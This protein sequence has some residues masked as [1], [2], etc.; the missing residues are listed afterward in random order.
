MVLLQQARL[1]LH[2]CWQSNLKNS[3]CHVLQAPG[4]QR[5]R[6]TAQLNS[7]SS[8]NTTYAA[9]AKQFFAVAAAAT[10]NGES[11]GTCSSPSLGQQEPPQQLWRSVQPASFVSP[12]SSSDSQDSQPSGSGLQAVGVSSSP[13]SQSSSKPQQRTPAVGGNGKSSSQHNRSSCVAPQQP[14]PNQ[15]LTG[16][17]IMRQ[18]KAAGSWQELQQL[19]LQHGSELNWRHS[20]ALLAH[21][22]QLSTHHQQEEPHEQQQQ[23]SVMPSQ[24]QTFGEAGPSLQQQAQHDLQGFVQLSLLPLLDSHLQSYDARGLANCLW[25]IAKLRAVAQPSSSWLQQFCSTSEPLLQQFDAQQLS[26]TLWGLVQLQHVPP[27]AWLQSWYAAMLQACSPE[28]PAWQPQSVSSALW[29]VAQLLVSTEGSSSG[30]SRGSSRSGRGSSGSRMGP[31]SDWVDQLLTAALQRVAAA[32]GSRGGQLCSLAGDGQVVSNALWACVQLQQQPRLPALLSLQSWLQRAAAAETSSGGANWRQQQLSDQSLA[33]CMWALGKLQQQHQ[34]QQHSQKVLAPHPQEQPGSNSDSRSQSKVWGV[35]H[36]CGRLLLK[37]STPRLQHTSSQHMS[38]LVWGAG[39]LSLR[40]QEPVMA[41]VLQQLAVRAD[42]LTDQQVSNLLWGLSHIK[43][44][45]Q[46]AQVSQQQQLQHPQHTHQQQASQE[47]QQQYQHQHRQQQAGCINQVLQ[48]QVGRLQG[49]SSQA[50][51][52]TLLSLARIQ[53][54]PQDDTLHAWLHALSSRPLASSSDAVATVDACCALALLRQQQ[55]QQAGAASSSTGWGWSRSSY[56]SS[57]DGQWLQGLCADTGNRLGVFTA[58]QLCALGWA[59]TLLRFRAPVP[60]LMAWQLAVVDKADSMS[61]VTAARALRVL[62]DLPGVAALGAA[63]L[64]AARTRLAAA[65]ARAAATAAAAGRPT[66]SEVAAAA[67]AVAAT[68]SRDGAQRVEQLLQAVPAVLSSCSTR[69]LAQLLCAAAAVQVPL[70]HGLLPAVLQHAQ[71]QHRQQQLGS[72]MM[73]L[74]VGVAKVQR[75]QQLLMFQQHPPQQQQ[76]QYGFPPSQSDH[77]QQ[78]QQELQEPSIASL[79]Q[80]QEQDRQQLLQWLQQ[81]VPQLPLS[82]ASPAYLSAVLWALAVLGYHPGS[83]WLE[84]WAQHSEPVLQ[85]MAPQQLASCGWALTVLRQ[86]PSAQ[87][88]AAWSRAVAQQLA[89]AMISPRSLALLLYSSA[90]LSCPVNTPWLRA[91]GAAAVRQVESWT[92]ADVADGLWGL[93]QLGLRAVADDEVLEGLVIGLVDATAAQ[94]QLQQLNPHRQLQVLQAAVL[95]GPGTDSMQHLQQQQVQGRRQPRQQQPELEQLLRNKR[96]RKLRWLNFRSYT[97]AAVAR[98]LA[99]AAAQQQQGSSAISSSGVP[100]RRAVSGAVGKAAVVAAKYVRVRT[101]RDPAAA[102]AVG[103]IKPGWYGYWC[104]CSLQQLPQWRPQQIAAALAA[105]AVLGYQPPEEWQQ[106]MLAHAVQQQQRLSIQTATAIQDALVALQSPLVKTWRQPLMVQYV[107]GRHNS[108]SAGTVSTQEL[109]VPAAAAPLHQQQQQ[110]RVGARRELSYPHHLRGNSMRRLQRRQHYMRLLGWWRQQQVI[111]QQY[112]QQR[113]Q[114]EEDQWRAAAAAAGVGSYASSSY[115][116]VGSYS[117]VSSIS[118]SPVSSVSD[119]ASPRSSIDG[120]AAAATMGAVA[121][122]SSS[123]TAGIVAP[124]RKLDS[125]QLLRPTARPA[126]VVPSA[127]SSDSGSSGSSSSSS[128]D[129]SSSGAASDSSSLQPGAAG[130][131]SVAGAMAAASGG[132]RAAA[133]DVSPPAAT[134]ASNGRNVSSSS[135]STDTSP[136]ASQASAVIGAAAVVVQPDTP[137]LTAAAWGH[138]WAAVAPAAVTEGGRFVQAGWGTSWQP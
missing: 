4:T 85:Q 36:H 14:G 138:S 16:A 82:I 46:H 102:A 44:Q 60:W 10:G 132:Q 99:A 23:H 58:E 27:R 31:S 62:Q 78:Q 25:A 126:P 6:P 32:A 24:Q 127:S 7:H 26:S 68:G 104:R 93:G 112:A 116:S 70:P 108:H 94:G 8:S 61:G 48:A 79:Q 75:Q 2:T 52:S 109:Q 22:A 72:G 42:S 1:F 119:P 56:T 19:V 66:A 67:A 81:V 84:V 57:A 38:L 80:G 20:S 71:H 123:T 53:H 9:G 129:D 83:S 107:P 65:A 18:L 121:S 34:E 54:I 29:A 125:R 15:Q 131:P 115:S 59:M 96:R 114:Q 55:Q 30:G 135:S 97:A 91:A 39:A 73:S 117:S 105:F 130:D 64:H 21:L 118:T 13:G 103:V 63:A 128:S 134:P 3:V 12:N 11:C 95:L 40:M 120:A 89:G 33:N 37:L 122:S 28:D 43:C 100:S 51:G 41:A 74:L 45:Q 87:W 76:Q 17:A 49:F 50:I 88:L 5:S 124:T 35:V 90:T 98:Q 113:Q 106:Q 47:R 101:G 136:A 137:S 133:L 92:A 86:K 77:T 110:L 111:Q 69:Q